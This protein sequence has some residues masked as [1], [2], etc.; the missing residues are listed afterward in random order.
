MGVADYMAECL[1][2]P[3]DGY[4]ATRD[5]LGAGGDFVTAPEISQMFGELLG[6]WLAQVWMDQGRPEG[7]LAE[8]GPGRGTLMADVMRATRGVEGF[9]AALA[10]HLVEASPVLRGIQA[11]A[12]AANAPIFHDG[13]GDLP[14]A[15]LFLLANEFFDALPIRQFQMNDA[16]DWQERQVGLVG[17]RLIWGLAPPSPLS[18]QDG[19]TPG[20][21]VETCAPGEAI[22]QEV[23]R[24]I[25]R[26]GGA[27]L[28][29]DYGDTD[30]QGDTFQAVK[31][32]IYADPLEDPGNTDLTAHVAF[33]PLARAAAPAVASALVPQ[34]VFLER[35]G[36]TARAQALARGLCDGALQAHISAHRR[37][38]HP[39]EMGNLF[40]V[41]SLLPP[42]TLPP[43]A[44]EP[45]P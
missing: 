36:I 37:L 42:N 19:F 33:G 14:E 3:K 41:M 30:S 43:P 13:V 9:H 6:L 17:D 25:A 21:V 32:H 5:P 26:H 7:I 22:A 29:V 12:L 2:D 27:A 40:K 38:T 23:G 44:L 1:H 15:P 16:C 35:L 4:Y 11:K 8:L 45:A 28:I 24:R 31:A 10:L 34:G 39:Q 20:M 18:V